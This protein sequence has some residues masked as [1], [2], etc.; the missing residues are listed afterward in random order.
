M[1][2]ED[3][4]NLPFGVYVGTEVTCQSIRNGFQIHLR[5]SLDICSFLGKGPLSDIKLQQSDFS[6]FVSNEERSLLNAD[7]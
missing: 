6:E 7:P 1:T 2:G 4:H 5:R 3:R